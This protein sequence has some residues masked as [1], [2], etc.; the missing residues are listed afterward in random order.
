MDPTETPAA[1][2]IIH[3][4]GDH[5]VFITSSPD[6]GVFNDTDEALVEILATTVRAALDRTDQGGFDRG[7]ASESDRIEAF[8]GT[9]GH[10][11]RNPL[12]VAAG[13]LE[14]AREEGGRTRR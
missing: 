11:L 3:P 2:G 8:A 4:L 9:L 14:L 6:P 12:G 1:S 7:P 13:H 10:D 5:G